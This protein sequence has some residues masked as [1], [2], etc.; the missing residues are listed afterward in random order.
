MNDNA[1][2]YLEKRND[3]LK[4]IL[5]HQKLKHG[6]IP[7]DYYKKYS[8][9]LLNEYKNSRSIV[10]SAESIG[11]NHNI[12]MNWYIQ[13]QLGNPQFRGFYLV[14]THINQ[15]ADLNSPCS[16]D[17]ETAV[18]ETDSEQES[19][20]KD[21]EGEYKISE[22]GDGWSYKTY[23]GGEKIFLISGKLDDLKRKV[24]DRNLPID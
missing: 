9:N 24:K 23:V 14:I 8:L 20:P 11:I 21:F 5:L 16:S 15:S 13:G 22:Y 10:K 19:V 4:S 7:M 3:S 17:V 6:E 12:A 1:L 2:K 18:C